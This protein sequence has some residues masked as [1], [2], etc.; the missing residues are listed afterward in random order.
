[1]VVVG[2]T[3]SCS[4]RPSVNFRVNLNEVS[5]IERIIIIDSHWFS[6]WNEIR[7]ARYVL[8]KEELLNIIGSMKLKINAHNS[9]YQTKNNNSREMPPFLLSK[10]TRFFDFDE[11]PAGD[12][13]KRPYPTRNTSTIDFKGTPDYRQYPTSIKNVSIIGSLMNDEME[14]EIEPRQRQ[15]YIDKYMAG[16][17]GFSVRKRRLKFRRSTSNLTNIMCPKLTK[18]S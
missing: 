11:K 16:Q 14:H 17:I 9:E 2:S 1:M 7:Y 8:M 18:P 13:C 10:H 12:S 5:D 3:S 6:T 4:S 15:I